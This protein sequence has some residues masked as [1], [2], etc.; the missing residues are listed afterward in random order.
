[1]HDSD[2][3]HGTSGIE[4][5]GAILNALAPQQ[6]QALSMLYLPAR[7]AP[8]RLLSHGP[9]GLLDTPLDVPVLRDARLL[10]PLANMRGRILPLHALA[11]NETEMRTP[12]VATAHAV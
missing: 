2:R 8:D 3:L 7:Y 6:R 5:L 4:H 1:M 12:D 10:E 11:H 9:D